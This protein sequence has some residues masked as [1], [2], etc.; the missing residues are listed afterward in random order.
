MQLMIV[1]LQEN[2][3]RKH[4]K[5]VIL[6]SKADIYMC[7]CVCVYIY[8][9]MYTHTHT[10]THTH[11]YIHTYTQSTVCFFPTC[12]SKVMDV[13]SLKSHDYFINMSQCKISANVSKPA[14]IY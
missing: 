8:I 4:E 7:V 10:H 5:I 6:C 14:E 12:Y 9:Y 1:F 2:S 3:L 13:C 11:I